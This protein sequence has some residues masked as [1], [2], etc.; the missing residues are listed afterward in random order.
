MASINAFKY[1]IWVATLS[2]CL[3]GCGEDS[4]MAPADKTAPA[5]PTSTTQPGA[6]LKAVDVPSGTLAMNP[7]CPVGH[8]PVDPSGKK[9]KYKGQVYGFCCADCVEHFKADPG[10]YET[11]Q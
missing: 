7:M 2:I 5:L 11:A 1:S 6:S 3:A 4:E 8:E 9:V 10:K